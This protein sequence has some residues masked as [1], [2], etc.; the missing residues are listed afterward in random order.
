MEG[1][2]SVSKIKSLIKKGQKQSKVKK[3]K[4]YI[5]IKASEVTVSKIEKK[6]EKVL[7]NEGIMVK[8]QFQIGYKLDYYIFKS[9]K[10]KL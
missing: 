9:K 8:P 7:L 1:K 6:F 4:R 2:L 5:P 3:T 10:W